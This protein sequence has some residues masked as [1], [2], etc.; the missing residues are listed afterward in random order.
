MLGFA[1]GMRLAST[2]ALLFKCTLSC[3]APG[4]TEAKI[5]IIMGSL[6][7]W[8][9]MQRAADVLDELAIPY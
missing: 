1:A 6:S 7:D 2:P 9:T 8:P 4:M 5:G 3:W